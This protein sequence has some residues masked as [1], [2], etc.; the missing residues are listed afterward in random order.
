M[1]VML[2]Q[3]SGTPFIVSIHYFTAYNAVRSLVS[4]VKELGLSP[5]LTA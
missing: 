2:T 3:S 5:E 4:I 1:R